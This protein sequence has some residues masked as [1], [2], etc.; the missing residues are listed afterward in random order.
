LNIIG[1]AVYSYE[2]L[3]I[4]LPV[5]QI[6]KDKEAYKYQVF[7]VFTVVVFLYIVFGEIAYL[8]YGSALAP[9]AI[10]ISNLPTT[11]EYNLI[12]VA[13]IQILYSVTLLFTYPL[14]IYPANIIIE[15][16]LFGT[17]PKSKK[18]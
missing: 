6:T 14:C 12:I 18:R 11:P 8:A 3:G 4:I 9:N 5:W 16:Y 17:W 2:G 1:F 7:A 15:S 13:V 10:I